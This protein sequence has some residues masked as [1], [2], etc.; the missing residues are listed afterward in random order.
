[1]DREDNRMDTETEQIDVETD[2]VEYDRMS[3]P[4]FDVNNNVS[5]WLNEN[6]ET[7]SLDKKD[8]RS[9]TLCRV[10]GDISSGRHYGQYTCDGCSGFFMRSVRKNMAYRCKGNKNCIVDKKRRNQCQAC[11]FEKC[12]KVNMNR[13]AV[14]QERQPNNQFHLS[15]PRYHHGLPFM[16]P[17][18]EFMFSHHSLP[19]RLVQSPPYIE[20]RE[21]QELRELRV[22]KEENVRFKKD[23]HSNLKE[24]KEN[25]SDLSSRL[26]YHTVKWARSVPAFLELP[27]SDQIRLL[28]SSWAEIYVLFAFQWSLHISATDILKRVGSRLPEKKLAKVTQELKLFEDLSRRFEDLRVSEDE[29]IYLKSVVLFKSEVHGL[30]DAHHI[31]KC[32]DRAQIMLRDHVIAYQ[33]NQPARFGKLL[34]LLPEIKHVTAKTLEEMLFQ[35]SMGTFSFET[36]L[37]DL[38]KSP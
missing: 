36:L 26:L 33:S 30:L 34:L 28:E 23:N 6:T 1:M 18:A 4:T 37:A 29:F 35:Q 32:Q 22:Y 24:S 17:R 27:F 8:I 31:E 14:Q 19:T 3:S 21:L 38:F 12:L 16:Y 9:E 2:P 15:Q 10:C 13:Y 7:D 11:R 5:R 25:V 20:K